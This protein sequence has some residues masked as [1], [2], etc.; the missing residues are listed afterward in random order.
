VYAHRLIDRHRSGTWI[1]AVTHGDFFRKIRASFVH[2][3][4][5]AAGESR[6]QAAPAALA[7]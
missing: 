3:P 2:L 1:I 4:G 7:M 6:N 5:R